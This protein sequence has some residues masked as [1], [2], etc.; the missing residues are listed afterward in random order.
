MQEELG[1]E[2]RR[3]RRSLIWGQSPVSRSLAREG[4]AGYFHCPQQKHFFWSLLHFVS[5][6][7]RCCTARICSA[8]SIELGMAQHILGLVWFV[9]FS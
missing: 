6:Q 2:L 1:A 5:S 4:T 7:Q 8:G 3:R 9:L